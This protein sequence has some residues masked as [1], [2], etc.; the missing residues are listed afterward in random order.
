[1]SKETIKAT[2][3][4]KADSMMDLSNALQAIAERA[5]MRIV[6][7]ATVSTSISLD[8]EDLSD[9]IMALSDIASAVEASDG[10][11]CKVSAPGSAWHNRRLDPT[12][13][14]RMINEATGELFDD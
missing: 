3:S 2:I 4:L 1:M 13:M 11:E 12:P 6:Q 10:V 9:L 5:N 7:S 14:E 8:S